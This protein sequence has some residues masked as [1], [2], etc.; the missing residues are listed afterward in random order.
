MR[1]LN[2]DAGRRTEASPRMLNS[3]R[4]HNA[5]DRRSAWSAPSVGQDSGDQRANGPLCA[6][7]NDLLV[8]KDTVLGEVANEFLV[9][10]PAGLPSHACVL[11]SKFLK[12][13][14]DDAISGD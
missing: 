12:A 4:A 3:Y 6:H 14:W 11:S 9:A 10:H 2:K 13:N 1:A 7:I 8:M 5:L